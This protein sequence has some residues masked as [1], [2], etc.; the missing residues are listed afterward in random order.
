MQFITLARTTL[1]GIVLKLSGIWQIQCGVKQIIPK[2]SGFFLPDRPSLY[3]CMP[4]KFPTTFRTVSEVPYKLVPNCNK[5]R[6]NCPIQVGMIWY[7]FAKIAASDIDTAEYSVSRNTVERIDTTVSNGNQVKYNPVWLHAIPKPL[8]R[9]KVDAC[10]LN[11]LCRPTSRISM[12]SNRAC[13][14]ANPCEHDW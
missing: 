5:P 8:Q 2:H 10:G 14:G 6:Y 7:I 1:C 3:Q 12:E 11:S 4:S 13:H 9:C